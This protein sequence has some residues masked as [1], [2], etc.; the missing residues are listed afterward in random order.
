MLLRSCCFGAIFV[1]ITF[2]A[3]GEL[4]PLTGPARF[5]SD[6]AFL[7]YVQGQTFRYFWDEANA[8][9]GL[10][11]DRSAAGSAC[12]VAA[13]GFGLSA[14]N[15]GIERGWVE[16]ARGA[17]RVLTTLNGL[18][19]LPQGESA[20]GCAGHHGWFYHFLDMNTGLRAGSS[21]VSTIDTALLLMGAIDAGQFF[22]DPT[23]AAERRIRELADALLER[24]DWSF[25]VRSNEQ[26]I[27]MEW[28][29]E[30]GYGPGRWKGYNEA[31]CLYLIGL[32]ARTNGLS[33]RLWDSWTAGFDWSENAGRGF[34][35]CPSLFTHQYSQVWIDFR[36]IKDA[37][38]R[39]KGSDYFENS[40][41]ATLAQRHYAIQNPLAH[42]N[43]GTNEWGFTACDGPGIAVNGTAFPGYCARGA[44][45]GF[46]DGTI[47]PTAAASS[48]PFAPGECLPVL[49]HIYEAY[50][51]NLWT[52]E[53]FRDA[54]NIRAN[55]W[56]SD[57][58]GID[59]G[60]IVIMAENFRSGSTWTRMLGSSVIQRGLQRAGFTPPP[61]DRLKAKA[62][63][64]DQIELTWRDNSAYETG[65]QIEKSTDNVSFV[66]AA[67]TAP[68]TTRAVLAV[69]PGPT[70]YWRVRT[71][72]PAGVSGYRE[73]VPI[74]G[75]TLASA[76]K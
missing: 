32:G 62:L 12:S 63:S 10:V 43:Y 53:G 28:K 24:V 9:N 7:E 51:T 14:I 8:A 35:L 34:V 45:G 11:R 59:Q 30:N 42:P 50:G 74:N 54:Y 22:N 4:S 41:R 71:I 26:V 69:K 27:S 6:D 61:P 68:N 49:R 44:P 2:A 75:T 38:M 17:E 37:Y 58:I 72:G 56:D 20:R 67:T 13:V 40:R 5:A 33:E 21:E 70:Y 23:N 73:T 46:E 25:M 18:W 55:W 15:I 60:P 31:S 52:T 64:A 1:L 48:L 57:A 66:I 65:F 76:E 39:A 36:G 3:R 19:N 16:R 29:P 47:A